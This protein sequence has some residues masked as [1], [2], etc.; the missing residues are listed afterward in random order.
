MNSHYQVL[1]RF[2]PDK[3]YE[4][5]IPPR[6]LKF[7]SL[8]KEGDV[9]SPIEFTHS[10][11]GNL[12]TRE[13]S[14]FDT[15]L[16]I[17]KT[18]LSHGL[19]MGLVKKVELHPMSFKDFCKLET[20]EY[21]TNQL[22]GSK[23]KNIKS[24]Q[25]STQSQYLYRLWEF[26]NWIIGKSF[27]FSTIRY[28]DQDTFKKI[29]E[30]IKLENVEHFLK[31]FQESQNT[32]SEY[33]KIIKRFLMSDIH[34][35]VSPEYIKHKKIAITSY[36]ERNDSPLNFRFDSTAMYSNDN[37]SYE[38][39][40]LTLDDLLRMLTTGSA[41]LLD[42]AVVLSKF[43]RGLDNSTFVDRFNF[44]VWEQLVKWFGSV[45]YDNWDLT[46]CPVPIIVT[47]I[48]TNYKH[49]GFLDRDAI[50][51]IQK[52]LRY[53]YEKT[54]KVMSIREPLFINKK[55]DAIS[56]RWIQTVIQRLAK[57][58]GIQRKFTVNGKFKNEKTSHELRDLLKSTLLSCGVMQYVC[59]S[60]IGHK[61]GDSYEKQDKL[62]PEQSRIEYAKASD[63]INIFSNISHNMEGDFE[64]ESLRKEVE[65]LKEQNITNRK[66][67][68]DELAE[69]KSTIARLV[70]NE[71]LKKKIIP[72]TI[73]SN[74]G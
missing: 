17:V 41:S 60:A 9:I 59:E 19:Q 56:P 24:K 72:I 10:N 28:I 70:E 40:R 48:K 20:V 66:I 29:K 64:K 42:R 12:G 47:R 30:K 32:D 51:A 54:G 6:Y 43:H 55:G 11:H 39:R 53:R 26:N 45:E 67:H 4:I 37:D 38:D 22:R 71:S 3:N 36:F 57:N 50:D 35:K 27:E 63:K 15:S 8:L 31:L 14:S 58:A 73:F 25:Y 69:I 44:E 62:Y 21:F 13:T 1:E 65:E 18:G 61:I 46:K 5:R 2:D 16:W 52:Y 74:E 49:R 68:D 34:G 33:I 7:F 23:F